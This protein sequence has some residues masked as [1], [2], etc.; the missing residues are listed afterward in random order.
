MYMSG[1][2]SKVSVI[3]RHR[4]HELQL[5]LSLEK[6]FATCESSDLELNHFRVYY[7]ICIR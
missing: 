2:E 1:Q 6:Y 3:D 7:V 4:S 5:Q